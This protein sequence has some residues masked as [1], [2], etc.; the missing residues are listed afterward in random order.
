MTTAIAVLLIA[1]ALGE[2][3]GTLTVWLTY[4]RGVRVAEEFRAEVRDEEQELKAMGDVRRTMLAYDDVGS[5]F[6]VTALEGRF[7]DARRRVA[8]QLESSAM[9]TLGL[10]VFVV[11]ALCGLA[12]GLVALY[13]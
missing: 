7:R 10:W 1:A 3:F 9:T 4:R 8:D 12:A 2:L 13:H 6:R 11:G 5:S